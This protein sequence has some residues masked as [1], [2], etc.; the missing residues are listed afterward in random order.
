MALEA[1]WRVVWHVLQFRSG[2]EELMDYVGHMARQ[3]SKKMDS[4]IV[5]IPVNSL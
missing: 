3:Q 5:L 4:R 1:S 2:Q